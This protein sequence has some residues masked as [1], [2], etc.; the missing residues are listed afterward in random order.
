MMIS[1]Q[2]CNFKL[3]LPFDVGV[4]VGVWSQG[5][6][7]S[8]ILPVF[9]HF[10]KTLSKKW[11]EMAKVLDRTN[12]CHVQM[13]NLKQIIQYTVDTDTDAD[14]HTQITVEVIASKPQTRPDLQSPIPALPV[15][16]IFRKKRAQFNCENF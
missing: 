5:V 9:L 12:R 1:T 11:P 8:L 15:Y 2:H 13:F 7:V 6:F 10:H 16:P 14:T 3:N 4:L